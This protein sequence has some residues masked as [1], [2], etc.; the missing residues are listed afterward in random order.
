MD[1][2]FCLLF[3]ANTPFPTGIRKLTREVA[4]HRL[5]VV[6]VPR[7]NQSAFYES[8]L[9]LTVFGGCQLTST[10]CSLQV[11][12][13]CNTLL[14]LR[15]LLRVACTCDFTSQGREYELT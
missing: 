10:R 2:C 11:A 9:H 13:L 6:A 8:E 3:V 12:Y 7:C 1:L 14:H 4:I 5:Y 15:S